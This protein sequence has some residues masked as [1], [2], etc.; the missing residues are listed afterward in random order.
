MKQWLNSIF[1]IFVVFTSM[2]VA[3]QEITIGCYIPMTG[4]A[5]AMG[6]V[7]WKGVEIAQRLKPEVLGKKVRLILA[8][9]KSDKIEAATPWPEPPLPNGLPSSIS[10]P[11]PPAPW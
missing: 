9:T 6:Q 11:R 1:F 4:S 2:P 10:P 3:G 5:A 8:D 7:V